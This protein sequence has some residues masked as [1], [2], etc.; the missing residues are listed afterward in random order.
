MAAPPKPGVQ[1]S[2]MG[3]YIMVASWWVGSTANKPEANMVLEYKRDQ[4]SA[5]V[6]TNRAQLATFAKRM[7][8]VPAK[9]EVSSIADAFA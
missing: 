2:N 3:E 8:Y 1:A 5:G 7:K 6:L 4:G 9:P